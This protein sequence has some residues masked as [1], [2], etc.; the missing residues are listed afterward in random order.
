MLF[1]EL[2]FSNVGCLFKGIVVRTFEGAAV[3]RGCECVGVRIDAKDF[4]LIYMYSWSNQEQD[5]I[6]V[7]T[8][9][10]NAIYSQ[11]PAKVLK[12]DDKQTKHVETW[13]LKCK[14]QN[15]CNFVLPKV[16]FIQL[17]KYTI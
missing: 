13:K 3:E 8:A 4:L 17:E 1:P 7:Y 11:L 16:E 14:I 10:A 9:I 2:H 5:C 12:T 6:I 15:R